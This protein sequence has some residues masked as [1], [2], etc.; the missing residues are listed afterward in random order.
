MNR[1]RIAVII[2]N[3]RTA[4]LVIDCL[5][6]LSGEL[7]ADVDVAI[8]VDNLSGDGSID[9]IEY[10]VGQQKW[11]QWVTIIRSDRNGGYSYGNNLGI[12]NIDSEIF[13]F[14][15]SDTLI[16]QGA[17]ECLYHALQSE[18]KVGIIGP[19]LE[20][21]DGEVQVSCFRNMTPVSELLAAACTGI[22]TKLFRRHDVP[23]SP[24]SR[25]MDADWISFAFVALRRTVVEQ[26]GMLDEGY[27][28]YFE[29]LDYC[30][31]VRRRGWRI[32]YCPDARVVHLQSGSSQVNSLTASRGRRP[33]YYYASRSR[34]FAKYYGRLGLVCA[35]LLWIAGRS[36]SLLRELSG[37][38]KPHVCERESRDIWIN[39]WSPFK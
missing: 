27:F 32:H 39:W 33:A 7:Q 31:R 18:Q 21:P 5:Q 26:I 12:R 19:R 29:D 6:S 2:I 34:Y 17:V 23:V 11:N 13:I 20:W 8:V 24:S 4:D 15:N 22:V 9:R 14:A 30:R 28:M 1:K 10:E 3:Y 25:P 36:I 38:K 37:H 35:N 16:R